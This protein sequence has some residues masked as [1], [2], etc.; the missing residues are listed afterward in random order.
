[1]SV[2]AESV[3]GQIV[4]FL[5]G[6][7]IFPYPEEKPGFKIPWENVEAIIEKKSESGDTGVLES[8]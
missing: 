1:M 4:R 7:R 6:R 2:V 8:N 5:S 3:L